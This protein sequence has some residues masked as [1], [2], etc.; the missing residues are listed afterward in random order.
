MS[1]SREFLRKARQVL[2][3]QHLLDRINLEA[4]RNEK[5]NQ[6]LDMLLGQIG[7]MS[8]S[9]AV[10]GLEK[11]IF[12]YEVLPG[13]PYSRYALPVE[14]LPSRD[15]RPRYGYSKGVIGELDR[16][17][18]AHQA[19]YRDF[20]A[21]M[22]TL[23]LRS[24]PI[25]FDH[26]KATIPG[27][28]GGA[29]SAFDALALYAMLRKHRPKVYMEIGSGMT[30]LFARQAVIDGGLST[31]IISIDP[32]PRQ[33]IDEVCDS[34]IRVALETCDPEI[35]DQ[36][37]PGDFLFLDGSHR[38]FMN[39]D[40]TVFFI[41]V[42]PRLKPG[43]IVHI[44]DILLPYDYPDSFKSWYWNEQ[45]MLAVYMMAAMDKLKPLLPTTW[46]CSSPLLSAQLDGPF[47]D[48]GGEN[49]NLSWKGGGSM[50]FT[51]LI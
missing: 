29:I 28:I 47:V 31:K 15:F 26:D 20:V 12:D 1:L 32:E 21:F 42:L 25:Q 49:E 45:Y 43:V 5:L 34:V 46:I 7:H 13:T 11:T 14:Y 18:E 33:S 51:K 19:D 40:V 30:T 2:G 8:G 44:H 39:S 48:L 36:L 38:S 3:T 10:Q 17:F 9:K 6:K 41:D 22:R 37:E 27:W 16:W 4:D 24:I 23:D 35:F 50:W